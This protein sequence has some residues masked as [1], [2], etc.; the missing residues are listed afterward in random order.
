MAG[1]KAGSEQRHLGGG[2]SEPAGGDREV[3]RGWD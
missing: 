3:R 1:L 2:E